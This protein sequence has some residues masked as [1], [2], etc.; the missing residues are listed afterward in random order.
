MNRSS[1]L[2]GMG[3]LEVRWHPRERTQSGLLGAVGK[4]RLLSVTVKVGG[5]VQ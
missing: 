3:A 2:D 5:A 4:E 1:S